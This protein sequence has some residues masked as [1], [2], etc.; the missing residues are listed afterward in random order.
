MHFVILLYSDLIFPVNPKKCLQLYK[1]DARNALIGKMSNSDSY[2]SPQ[3]LRNTTYTKVVP[4]FV[5]PYNIRP[6]VD[7]NQTSIK[8]DG[9]WL[10]GNPDI[11]LSLIYNH[12]QTHIIKTLYEKF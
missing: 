12:I 4:E 5:L 1:A 9:I 2:V 8:L 6:G 3:T 7:W 10:I 11:Q